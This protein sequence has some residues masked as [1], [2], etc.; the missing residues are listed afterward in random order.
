MR[1]V[2]RILFL[3]LPI[4]AL[5]DSGMAAGVSGFSSGL[6][7]G[8]RRYSAAAERGWTSPA[9]DRQPEITDTPATDEVD[10]DMD[11]YLYGHV[12]DS[13]EWHHHD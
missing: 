10:L 11:E 12:R 5:A 7:A 6:A 8:V 3:L 1:S 2:L 13:Y 4:F 9:P